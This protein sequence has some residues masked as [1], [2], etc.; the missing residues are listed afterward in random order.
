MEAKFQQRVPQK[1]GIDRPNL[2]GIPTQTKTLNWLA[3]FQHY[4]RLH[5]ISHQLF[6]LEKVILSLIIILP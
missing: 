3:A 4:Y 5:Y 1:A 6:V 2:T